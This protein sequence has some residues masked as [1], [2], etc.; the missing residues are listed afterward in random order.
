V[1]VSPFAVVTVSSSGTSPTVTPLPVTV[2]VAAGFITT[3]TPTSTSDGARNTRARAA[4]ASFFITS[5]DPALL[6]GGVELGHPEQVAGV[7][8]RG[9]E[10]ERGERYRRHGGDL[11]WHS[12]SIR[13]CR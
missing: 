1:K 10:E 11:R 13:A 3:P 9:G 4:K 5:D 8:G 6:E 2:Q 12:A 7:E